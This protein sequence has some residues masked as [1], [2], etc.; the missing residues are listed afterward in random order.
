MRA[1]DGGDSRPRIIAH[2]TRSPTASQPLAV[3]DGVF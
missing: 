3:E 2:G 1:H